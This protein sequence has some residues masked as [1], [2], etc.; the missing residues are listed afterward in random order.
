[1]RIKY[2][3]LVIAFGLM[4]RI[5]AQT[6]DHTTGCA[7]LAV[8]FTAPPGY[9]S[10]HW[11]F[12]NGGSSDDAIASRSYPKPGTYI[13]TLTKSPGSSKKDTIIITVFAKPIPKIVTTDPLSGCVPLTV[14]LYGGRDTIPPGVTIKSYVFDLGDGSPSQP[15]LP[16]IPVIK[17]YTKVGKIKVALEIQTSEPSCNTTL[18]FPDY[19]STSEPPATAFTT[20]PTPPSACDPPLTVSFTNTTPQTVPLAFLWKVGTSPAFMGVTPPP[21]TLT[22]VGTYTVTLTATD[23]N[24]CSKS[25]QTIIN[26]GK[27]K[28]SFT[29]PKAVCIKSTVSFINNSSGGSYS[30]DFGAGASPATSTLTNPAIIYN[31]PGEKDVKLTVTSNGCSKDTLVKLIVEDPVVDFTANPVYS[32][33]EPMVVNFNG[34]MTGGTPVTWAWSFNDP[35]YPLTH[36]NNSSVLQNPTHT[37]KLRDSLYDKRKMQV[38]PVRLIGI[39]EAGCRDTII[40]NDTLFVSWARFVPDKY[41]G[42]AP[43]TIA[44]ADSSQSNKLKEPLVKWEWDY[45]DGTKRTITS[46][47]DTVKHTYTNPGVYLVQLIVTN[48]NGCT[49]TSYQVKIEVGDVKLLSF[50]ASPQT[51]CPGDSILL[52]N[53]TVDKTGIDAWHY[54]SDG[55]LFSHCADLD[56][57]KVAFDDST[58]VR[59]IILSADYN[60]CVSTSASIAVNVKGPIAKI[61]SKQTCGSKRFEVELDNF[62]SGLVTKYSWDFGDGTKLDTT[63]YVKI[64]HTYAATGDYKVVLTATN[65]T[66]GCNPSIDTVTIHI[67]DIQSKFTIQRELCIE[68]TYTL[69]ASAS[70]DVNAACFRGYSWV[71]SDP[72]KRPITYNLPTANTKFASTGDQ[73]VS[74]VVEDINGCKDTSSVPVKV[75]KVSSKFI[76]SKNP[77]CL[78]VTVGLKTIGTTPPL[79]V[80][81][82]TITSWLWTFGDNTAQLPISGQNGDTSHTYLTT[83]KDT[84]KISLLVTDVLGC[85]NLFDTDLIIYRPKS[86]I[87]LTSNHPTPPANNIC[88]GEVITLNAA[89]DNL[90]GSS[91]KYEWN[92]G[93][94]SAL[95]TNKAF[96]YT[97]PKSGTFP[98]T[99]KFTEIAT[100]CVGNLSA[101][102]VVQDYPQAE[103]SSKPSYAEVLCYP[104]VVNFKDSS[105]TQPGS[106]VTSWHWD[107][108]N[109]ITA[110]GLPTASTTF[111]KGT[112]DVKLVVG[113]SFGCLDTTTQKYVVVGPEGD[114]SVTPNTGICRGD[115]VT[116][117]TSNLKDVK[118][119]VWD[120]GD[121]VKQTETTAGTITHT[122]SYVPASGTLSVFLIL[123]DVNQVC[124]LPIPIDIDIHNIKSDFT[125]STATLCKG[126]EV[127]IKNTSLNGDSF[128]WNLGDNTTSTATD[129][130]IHS[131]NPEGKYN[132]TLITK[133]NSVSC[134]DTLTKTIQVMPLPVVTAKGDSICPGSNGVLSVLPTDPG[135]TY[136][137]TPTTNLT[138]SDTLKPVVTVVNP[139]ESLTYT[140]FVTDTNGCVGSDKALLYVFPKIPR[141]DFDTVIV[142]GDTIQL[143][144][145]N[146]N[147]GINFTW[148]PTQG[149]SCLQCSKP[150]VHP[151]KDI[152]YMVY[153]EDKK[154]CSNNT[155][156]F[157]IRIKPETFI[158]VPTTFTPN[159]DGNND[160]IYVKGWGIKD[161]ISFQIYNRWGEL[162]FETSELSEGWNGYYKDV[163]QNNDVYTYKVVARMQ[164]A[165]ESEKIETLQGH[166]SLMR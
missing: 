152:I 84:V 15:T 105:I 135:F 126:S 10:Y 160:I 19:I 82:T 87:T 59:N 157:N 112:F 97:Y 17:T 132:I 144:I 113:T 40:K 1:M 146:L 134:R 69:D 124:E 140:A 42:C 41:Q 51:V 47:Q 89:D 155:G 83:P 50:T 138:A 94:G 148:T 2:F 110:D 131:Y 130:I 11:D 37:F 57:I 43:L 133:S 14:N 30:W 125:L 98:I 36:P 102:V 72:M 114:Y 121:G 106:P 34:T 127:I 68:K 32:C 60:G 141:I 22:T 142:I 25:A 93:D 150:Q 151:L 46:F 61:A 90:H 24:K 88:L 76:V 101:N 38:Y 154:Q 53:T 166:I 9:T 6:A 23:S 71:F 100:G 129:S 153:M 118:S 92:L 18:E 143:P 159:G 45:G 109:G 31:T 56:V 99:L 104:R 116:F 55:D 66:S 5:I 85:T 39:S 147:G 77:V 107:F 139:P 128:E 91:L 52:T 13:V 65:D 28:A 78:P 73:T 137:W 27:P 20:N 119:Y 7:P 8:T 79:T 35:G 26:I 64:T 16:G 96:N 161:L 70:I 136:R 3:F 54:S 115:V 21:V 86:E 49:D 74:L 95:N 122:Y 156:V 145:D 117:T 29:A 103:L 81:D 33:S 123:Q 75:F 80:S 158:K 165:D 149:L 164:T 63:G 163:L 4:S 67:R 12:G 62:K 58:G 120:F 111:P 162:V 48:K 108:G 44:F